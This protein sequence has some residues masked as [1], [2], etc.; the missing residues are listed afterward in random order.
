[1]NLIDRTPISCPIQTDSELTARIESRAISPLGTRCSDIEH[2][3]HMMNLRTRVGGE[4]RF[5]LY[6]GQM[7]KHVDC[8]ISIR[9]IDLATRLRE[10]ASEAA[11]LYAFGRRDFACQQALGHVGVHREVRRAGGSCFRHFEK[12]GHITSTGKKRGYQAKEHFVLAN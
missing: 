10:A 9:S 1:M 11:D 3:M 4:A 7:K 2:Q 6:Q 12:I 5:G 8:A